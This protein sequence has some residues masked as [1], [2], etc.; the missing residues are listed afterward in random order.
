MVKA[1]IEMAT[2]IMMSKVD[3]LKGAIIKKVSHQHYQVQYSDGLDID[4]N[5][6]EHLLEVG[7]FCQQQGWI[8]DVNEYEDA[9]LIYPNLIIRCRLYVEVKIFK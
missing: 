3:A 7:I 1:T 9:P 4:E 2:H 6:E 5:V 8:V